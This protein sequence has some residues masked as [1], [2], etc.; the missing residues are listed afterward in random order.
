MTTETKADEFKVGDTVYCVLWGKGKVTY[1]EYVDENAHYPV[2]VNFERIVPMWYTLDGKYS[3]DYPR[4]LF[5]SEPKIEASVTRP[6]VPTLVGKRVVVQETD[7]RD[8]VIIVTWEDQDSFG[9]FN[10]MFSKD[11]GVVF[12]VSS[13]NLLDDA[14]SGKAAF[15]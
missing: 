3:D 7:R 13:E 15:K 8:V 1:V 6:F 10:Y 9:N 5:F 12:E 4:T 11:K 2:E 14:A